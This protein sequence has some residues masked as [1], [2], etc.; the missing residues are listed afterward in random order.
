MTAPYLSV[1][2]SAPSRCPLC[3]GRRAVRLVVLLDLPSG[4]AVEC[5]HC[6]PREGVEPVQIPVPPPYHTDR[7]A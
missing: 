7:S 6:S 4:V 3:S 5:P 1:A 2:A